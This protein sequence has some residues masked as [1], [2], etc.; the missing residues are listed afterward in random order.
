[1]KLAKE[2]ISLISDYYT[3]N[4]L[5]ANMSEPINKEYIEL[6]KPKVIGRFLFSHGY[7]DKN[8]A[9]AEQIKL[10]PAG[11]LTRV[12]LTI[13]GA[14]FL[15]LNEILSW[16]EVKV[17]LNIG[18]VQKLLRS[19]GIYVD[20]KDLTTENTEPLYVSSDIPLYKKDTDP[21]GAYDIVVSLLSVLFGKVSYDNSVT[22]EYLF[23][24]LTGDIY[25]WN[26]PTYKYGYKLA[27][28]YNTINDLL[29]NIQWFISEHPTLIEYTPLEIL[30]MTRINNKFSKYVIEEN[31]LDVVNTE[32]ED[33]G[34]YNLGLNLMDLGDGKW[35]MGN[36][37]FDFYKGTKENTSYSEDEKEFKL[38]DWTTIRSYSKYI[39]LLMNIDDINGES[40]S[41]IEKTGLII[42]NI[43]NFLIH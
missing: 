5:N 23:E 17:L 31:A 29:D 43:Q 18:S 36:T 15:Y 33:L 26:Q 9:F 38:I 14:I 40:R 2:L 34:L 39:D 6:F 19:D 12:D 10:V 24:R 1:M 27:L 28:S 42:R 41:E 30:G 22:T 11:L 7:I 37:M 35:G 20:Y 32:F 8:I 4:N 21:I 25:Y 3:S 13:K 16:N